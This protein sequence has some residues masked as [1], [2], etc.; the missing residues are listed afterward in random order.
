MSNGHA[1]AIQSEHFICARD[2]R[3]IGKQ[4]L[5]S[6]RFVRKWGRLMYPH[7]ATSR[8]SS[9]VSRAIGPGAIHLLNGLYD[10]KMDHQPVLAIVGQSGGDAIGGDFQ[11]EVGYPFAV[12]GCGARICAHCDVGG[13]GSPPHRSRHTHR[14]RSTNGHLSS[15][16]A[17]RAGVGVDRDGWLQLPRAD[18]AVRP[19]SCLPPRRKY[20][21]WD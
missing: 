5:V 19:S 17:R 18:R 7:W 9:T 10:A 16:S 4:S 2:P 21:G 12:Q 6:Y 3:W 15:L 8:H 13:T 20:C 11:Q 1:H 14:V